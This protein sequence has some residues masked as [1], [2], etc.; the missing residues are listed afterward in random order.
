VRTRCKAIL[1]RFGGV[2]KLSVKRSIQAYAASERHATFLCLSKLSTLFDTVRT[3]KPAGKGRSAAGSALG[4]GQVTRNM[5]R[6]KSNLT[7]WY[8]S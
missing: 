3:E 6:P 5:Y 4:E 8:G 2:P 7:S 1:P